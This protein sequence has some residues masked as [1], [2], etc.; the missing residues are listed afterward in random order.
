MCNL[1]WAP[2]IR[3]RRTAVKLGD[4]AAVSDAAA[5]AVALAEEAIAEE[6]QKKVWLLFF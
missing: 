5:V 1:D 6:T 4:D 2:S 3:V